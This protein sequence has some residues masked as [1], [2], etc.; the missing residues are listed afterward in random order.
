MKRWLFTADAGV[1]GLK[2]FL[3]TDVVFQLHA[4]REE[5]LALLSGS[6]SVMAGFVPGK[7]T[8]VAIKRYRHRF[9]GTP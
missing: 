7:Q 9:C 8:R 3:L 4:F 5:P 1:N 6:G 2:A